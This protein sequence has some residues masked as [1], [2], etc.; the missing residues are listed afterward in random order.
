MKLDLNAFAK[1]KNIL[2][3]VTNAEPLECDVPEVPF[4]TFSKNERTDPKVFFPYAKSIIVMAVPY[5][6]MVD[7]YPKDMRRRGVFSVSVAQPDYH[8]VIRKF[9]NELDQ[10]IS[11]KHSFVRDSYVDTGP[12]LERALAVRAGLGFIGLNQSLITKEFGS[13][14]NLGYMVTDLELEP[15]SGEVRNSC[16]MCGRGLRSCPTGSITK[17]CYNY[18]KCISWLTQSPKLDEEQSASLNFHLYGCDECQ[19]ACPHNKKSIGVLKSE[20][21]YPKIETILSLTGSGFTSRFKDTCIY[22]RGSRILKRN[23]EIALKNE[24]SDT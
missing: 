19:F 8:S 1:E 4:V 10:Y 13:F 14:V 9:L 6:W 23:A 3:G 17:N 21:V 22:W 16:E 15:F 2:L 11:E 20:D 24:K 18:R 12:L 5:A 7:A